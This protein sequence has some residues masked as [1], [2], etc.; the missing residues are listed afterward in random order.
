[1]ALPK[2]M[3]IFYEYFFKAMV[4]GAAWK[5]RFEEDVRFGTNILEGYTQATLENN[6]FAWVYEYVKENPGSTIKTEYDVAG[7]DNATHDDCRFFCRDLDQVEIAAPQIGEDGIANGYKLLI[8]EDKDSEE[9]EQARKDNELVRKR[10]MER[11]ASGNHVRLNKDMRE[12]LE[13]KQGSAPSNEGQVGTRE[14]LAELVLVTIPCL[15]CLCIV[16]KMIY[17]ALMI[18]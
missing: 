2:V 14:V 12:K 17:L 4:G 18:S 6:Y 10:V 11:I 8:D 1:M 9:I 5:K 13:L 16:A 7:D 3:F 15:S